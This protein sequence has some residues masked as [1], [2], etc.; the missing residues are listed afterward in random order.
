M[1][2]RKGSVNNFYLFIELLKMEQKIHSHEYLQYVRK[3]NPLHTFTRLV[4]NST[5]IIV[6]EFI[7]VAERR[8]KEGERSKSFKKI[9]ILENKY[10]LRSLTVVQTD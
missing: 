8:W 4:T 10:Y 3:K 1:E 5:K 9:L 7:R 6:N 2:C